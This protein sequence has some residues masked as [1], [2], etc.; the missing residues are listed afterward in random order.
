MPSNF[1]DHHQSPVFAY[2]T[3]TEIHITVNKN[4]ESITSHNMVRNGREEWT[5]KHAD[6]RINELTNLFDNYLNMSMYWSRG[7][8]TVDMPN[9][10]SFETGSELSQENLI[11]S[12]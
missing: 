6:E 9:G 10:R 4:M 12:S 3:H 2:K 5:L 1:D 11:P 8:R 7:C